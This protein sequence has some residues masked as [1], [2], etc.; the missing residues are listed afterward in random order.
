MSLQKWE[1]EN[2]RN[3]KAKRQF[4]ASQAERQDFAQLCLEK[5]AAGMSIDDAVMKSREEANILRNFD[6]TRREEIATLRGM[7]RSACR[8]AID[9]HV[10]SIWKCKWNSH[11]LPFDTDYIVEKFLPAA[12][13][14][15][16]VQDLPVD[17]RNFRD[18]VLY[19][20]RF[21]AQAE[22]AFEKSYPNI[23]EVLSTLE[24]RQPTDIYQDIEKWVPGPADG[25]NSP[26][27]EVCSPEDFLAGIEQ[28]AE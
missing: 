17:R 20:G 7:L 19:I 23:A 5:I 27:F 3:E 14:L 26:E 1:V 24:K 2:H 8:R 28:A 6:A 10:E 4:S 13:Q 18:S 22:A 16:Q 12:K 9:N 21:A 25:G 15:Q 11:R